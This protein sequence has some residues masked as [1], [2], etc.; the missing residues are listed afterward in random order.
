[1]P[2]IK[3]CETCAQRGGEKIHIQVSCCARCYMHQL[4]LD[5]YHLW[6]TGKPS[7]II[8]LARKDYYIFVWGSGD[9]VIFE[10]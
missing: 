1:M 2:N 8:F 3:R 7:D 6:D 10:L 4:Y 5:V 9:D